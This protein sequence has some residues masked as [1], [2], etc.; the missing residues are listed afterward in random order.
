M[1]L[2]DHIRAAQ[3][4]ND[5]NEIIRHIPYMDWLGIH[6]EKDPKDGLRAV[7]PFTERI[8]GNPLLPAIHGGVTGAFL[9]SAAQMTIFAELG[10]EKL[11]KIVNITIDY[12]RSGRPQDTYA[13]GV[14][15]RQ[16]RRV[17]NVRVDAWQDDRNHPIA[18]A[19]THFLIG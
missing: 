18:S 9:E 3:D 4:N 5:Y 13:Q 1:Q 14:V 8:I 10:T 12:L 17:A 6:L 2:L 7:L 19:H 11:P 16:G 15:T